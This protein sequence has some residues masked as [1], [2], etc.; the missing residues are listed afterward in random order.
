MSTSYY[1]LVTYFSWWGARDKFFCEFTRGSSV[2]RLHRTVCLRSIVRIFLNSQRFSAKWMIVFENYLFSLRSGKLVLLLPSLFSSG[3]WFPCPLAFGELVL[4]GLEINLAPF[5]KFILVGT[6]LRIFCL[7]CKFDRRSLVW[8][9]IF[10][11]SNL[12]TRQFSEKLTWSSL[13]WWYFDS[14][15]V[16]FSFYILCWCL[17]HS[18]QQFFDIFSLRVLT[19]GIFAAYCSYVVLIYFSFWLLFK[20]I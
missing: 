5:A 12:N 10:S 19:Q 14:V 18:S 4:I 1:F 13:L 8:I 16:Q 3:R 9:F 7:A 17:S 11:V 6:C 2:A 20:Y 15:L